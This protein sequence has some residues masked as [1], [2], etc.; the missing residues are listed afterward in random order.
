[1]A[2]RYPGG[3]SLR[4]QKVKKVVDAAIPI[5]E[6]QPEG[7]KQALKEKQESYSKLRGTTEKIKAAESNIWL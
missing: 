1:V 4:K 2:S 6:E 7:Y 3:G 5:I